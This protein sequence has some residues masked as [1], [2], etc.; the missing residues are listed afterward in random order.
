MSDED[1]KIFSEL[2]RL[3]DKWRGR[4]IEKPEEWEELTKEFHGFCCRHPDSRLAL[5]MAVAAMWTFDDLYK[6]GAK[7]PIPDYFGRGDL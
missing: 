6:D 1:K 4:L 5:H 2:A 3:Y 7:P